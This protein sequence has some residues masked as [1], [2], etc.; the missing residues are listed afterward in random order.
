MAT[1]VAAIAHA[2]LVIR[3]PG[4]WEAT[5]G[6]LEAG[7]ALAVCNLSVIVPAIARLLGGDAEKYEESRD[8]ATATIGGSGGSKNTRNINNTMLSTFKV[9]QIGR[10]TSELQSPC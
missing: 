9:D 6:A 10:D 5:I 1:T 8:Y 3:V 2:V 4:T 7:V